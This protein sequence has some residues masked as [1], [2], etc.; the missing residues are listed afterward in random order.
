MRWVASRLP[1]GRV[2]D[3]G[4]GTGKLTR[5]IVACGAAVVAVEPGNEM[6][7]MLERVV[8]EAESLAGSAEAIPLPD[9]SVDAVVV[10]QAFHW[11][12]TSE[13]LAEMHRV[14]RP[15]GGYA[16]FWNERD[17]AA[18]LMRALDELVDALRPDDLQA[19]ESRPDWWPALEASPHFGDLEERTFAHRERLA[20]DTVVERI[21]SVSA[22]IAATA[23]EQARVESA[24]RALLGDDEIEFRMIT[25]VVVADRV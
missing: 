4:A 23:D 22:F 8:P 16:L 12:R 14:I 15:G 10:A 18:P 11:F 3:L 13:A 17:E 25:T 5:Q 7:S 6:R 24:V 19:S 2:L 21:R 9:A 1:F 20:R